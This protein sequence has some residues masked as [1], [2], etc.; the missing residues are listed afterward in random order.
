M[1]Y[2]NEPFYWM[3]GE[4]LTAD[5]SESI[6]VP[7]Q[8]VFLFC[9]LDER[10]LF[11]GL[12]STGL[13]SGNTVAEAR[14]SALYEL[15]ERDSEAVNP[16]HPSRCFRIYSKDDRMNAIFEDYRTRCIH[17]QFQ[18]I[19]PAFGIPCCTCFVTHRDGSVAKGGGANLN[20]KRAVL[21][22]LTETPYP[23]PLGP[24]SAPSPPDLPWLEFETLPDFSTGIPEQGSGVGGKN[25]AG[26]RFFTHLRGYFPPGSGYP[27]RQ[28][29]DSGFRDDG[30]LRPILPDQP[31][32]VQ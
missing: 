32:I 5:G 17:L 27:C 31:S 28:G 12:G 9:N 8:C 3:E 15:I 10:S 24:P 7:V 25:A 20:G 30:R 13:A 11:S 21:S 22:A 16:Y 29:A 4:R 2:R 18:D 6:W 26:Q 1:P 19:S 14:L 23:Y